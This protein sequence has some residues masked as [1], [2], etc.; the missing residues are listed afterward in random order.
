MVL[1]SGDTKYALTINIKGTGK[2]DYMVKNEAPFGPGTASLFLTSDQSKIPGSLSFSTG[3]VTITRFENQLADG[4]INAT[5]FSAI[6]KKTYTLIG[7][8]KNMGI[9]KIAN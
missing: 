3:K 2:G 7:E 9:N 6:N 4:M 8:F 1:S 5:A